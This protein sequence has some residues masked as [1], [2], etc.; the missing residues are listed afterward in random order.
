[1]FNEYELRM[2]QQRNDRILREA[3]NEQAI[4]DKLVKIG[5]RNRNR[6]GRRFRR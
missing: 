6:F 1:M 4:S 3:Q 2:V 5:R